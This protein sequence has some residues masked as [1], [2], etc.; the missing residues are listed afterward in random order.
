[1]CIRDRFISHPRG[2]KVKGIPANTLFT[3][4][5]G[6]ALLSA[7]GV[8]F[9]SIANDEALRILAD[10]DSFSVVSTP[11]I[12]MILHGISVS[13][14]LSIF[15]CI[16]KSE[17]NNALDAIGEKWK[18]AFLMGIGIYVGYGLLLIAMVFA[19]NVGYIVVFRQISIPIGV[20]LSRFILKEKVTAVMMIGTFIILGGLLIVGID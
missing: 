15:I 17:R 18:D 2:Q 8:A 10:L 7:I 9:Y 14:W 1:M 5:V 12:Y 4:T 3:A 16:N 19:T 6:Y 20:L 11:I 13:V